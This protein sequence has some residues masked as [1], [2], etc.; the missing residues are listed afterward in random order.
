VQDQTSS[1]ISGF[2][3]D[4]G[5]ALRGLELVRSYSDER[6]A[7]FDPSTGNIRYIQHWVERIDLHVTGFSMN[8]QGARVSAYFKFSRQIT[9]EELVDRYDDAEQDIEGLLRDMK[10]MVDCVNFEVRAITQAYARCRTFAL[11]NRSG[12]HRLGFALPVDFRT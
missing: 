3:K 6:A 10:K 7:S 2:E 1:F 8:I 5:I 4:H 9:I 11:P 12:H